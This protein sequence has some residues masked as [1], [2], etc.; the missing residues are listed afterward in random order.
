MIRTRDA[1][2]G[3]ALGVVLA[4]A[5]QTYPLMQ[6]VDFIERD[7]TLAF[8]EAFQGRRM[9]DGTIVTLPANP[10]VHVDPTVAPIEFHNVQFVA[11]HVSWDGQSIALVARDVV[12]FDR[13]R[14]D[15]N[16]V[17]EVYV[18]LTREGSRFRY[19]R[20]ELRGQPPLSAPIVGNPWLPLLHQVSGGV[21][22]PA[23]LR[24]RNPVVESWD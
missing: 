15:L 13:M 17:H 14:Q 4:L 3:I 5:L 21:S 20:F 9:T 16:P 12:G 23:N 7:A 24:D 2:L 22:A 6:A 11:K 1:V 18:T 19:D 10:A 8:Q